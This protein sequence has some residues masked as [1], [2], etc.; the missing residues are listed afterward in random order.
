VLNFSKVFGP[1]LSIPILADDFKP[2]KGILG[3]IQDIVV[4]GFEVENG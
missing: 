2:L 4:I 3:G 1:V